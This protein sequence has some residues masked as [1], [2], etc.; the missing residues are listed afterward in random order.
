MEKYEQMSTQNLS[1]SYINL[2]LE[3]TLNKIWEKFVC[4]KT[5]L[6]KIERYIQSEWILKKA[7]KSQILSWL[8]EHSD[9]HIDTSNDNWITEYNNFITLLWG[10]QDTLMSE[11]SENLSLNLFRNQ[12]NLKKLQ[13][14]KENSDITDDIIMIAKNL[15]VN[16]WY[17]NFWHEIWVAETVIKLCKKWKVDRRTLNLLVLVALFHDAWYTKEYDIDLEELACNLSDTYIPDNVFEKMNIRRD[18][19]NKMIMMT[20]I[21]NRNINN[22]EYIKILQD[23]DLWWLWEWPY[24]I[25]YSC[26]GMIDEWII[27]LDNFVEDEINFI[28]N[29]N[30]N[31][32]FFLSN[33]WITTLKSPIESLNIIKWRPKSVIEKSYQLRNKDITFEEF[34]KEIDTILS[35]K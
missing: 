14:I 12:E 8:F 33:V 35:Y 32:Q 31:W 23:A 28:N 26:M 1:H 25:L 15:S 9:D 30:I 21:S 34:K 17:H 19:F 27:S 24:Y 29:N 18:D 7:I 2:L 22:D 3:N 16:N 4:D 5:L 11:I 20:K 13:Y 6:N 10:N